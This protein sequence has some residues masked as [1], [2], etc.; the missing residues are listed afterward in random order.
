MTPLPFSDRSLP[1]LRAALP[2]DDEKG[3]YID[4]LNKADAPAKSKKQAMKALFT[5]HGPCWIEPVFCLSGN[6]TVELGRFVF[7]NHNVTLIAEQNIRL[8][9]GVFVGPGTIIS[10]VPL[11]TGE[12]HPPVNMN[13]APVTIGDNVWIGANAVIQPGVTIGDQAIV[14]AGAVV[15]DDVPA[16]TTV[17]GSPA[18]ILKK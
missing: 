2:R 9:E 4:V 14:G 7:L 16:N 13:N 15:F 11:D 5:C 3:P 18:T 1:S 12:I 10:T 8:G 6:A 17:A